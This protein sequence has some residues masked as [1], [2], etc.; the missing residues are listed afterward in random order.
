MP[1][2]LVAARQL[3]TERRGV[4][5]IGSYAGESFPFDTTRSHQVMM[6]MARLLDEFNSAN[7]APVEAADDSQAVLVTVGPDGLPDAIDLATDW[8]ARLGVQRFAAAITAASENAI[9][10]RAE[11]RSQA[12]HDHALSERLSQLSDHLADDQ[13]GN[14]DLLPPTVHLFPPVPL[15]LNEPARSLGEIIDDL[16]TRGEQT[17]TSLPDNLGDTTATQVSATVAAGNMELTMSPTGVL[18]CTVD[19]D[20]LARQET[21][22]VQDALSS[23]LATIRTENG[24]DDLFDP[25]PTGHLMAEIQTLMHRLT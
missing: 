4:T 7:A 24:S 25:D 19:V 20:W 14:A 22:R 23:A 11:Q 15:T 17:P 12:M 2:D 6:S 18:H 16:L 21:D 13:S 5:V 8:R 1:A 9:A 3:D 10:L